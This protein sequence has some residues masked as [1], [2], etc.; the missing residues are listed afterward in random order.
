MDNHQLHARI[1]EI[2]MYDQACPRTAK[3]NTILCINQQMT[4]SL[5]FNQ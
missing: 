3:K 2:N 5:C 4:I 1:L